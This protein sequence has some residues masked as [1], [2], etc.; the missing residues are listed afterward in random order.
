LRD[1][2]KYSFPINIAS[3]R[4]TTNPYAIRFAKITLSTPF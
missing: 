4:E 2:F 1:L 3:E